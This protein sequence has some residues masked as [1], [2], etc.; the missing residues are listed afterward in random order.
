MSLLDRS[1][2]SRKARMAAITP[3]ET[4]IAAGPVALPA[5]SARAMP[6]NTK[7]RLIPS[8][9]I[10]TYI[11]MLMGAVLNGRNRP[12]A[13]PRRPFR[14]GYLVTFACG[15]AECL[16]Q[17][18]PT[19]LRVLIHASDGNDGPWKRAPRRMRAGRSKQMDEQKQE[20]RNEARR[21]RRALKRAPIT[22]RGRC[23]TI[24]C[25][26]LNLSDLGACLKVENSRY[27][28]SCA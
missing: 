16:A 26:V 7:H 25:M 21:R 23:A 11:S 22:F 6:L 28:R 15:L 24:D 8:L 14:G 2:A 10:N 12:A 1:E 19:K 4:R 3:L 5:R 18:C 17:R 13:P 9:G 27:I 20:R